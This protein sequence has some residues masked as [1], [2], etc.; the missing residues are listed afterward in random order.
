MGWALPAAIGVKLARPDRQVVGMVGDGDFLMTMQE[1]AT[2][3][4]VG[5]PVVM[6][7]VN[8]QGWLAIKDLQM[9]AFGK[10]RALATDF[11]T[12]DGELYS[13]DIAATASAFGWHAQRRRAQGD[14]AGLEES[15]CLGQAGA[16]RGDGAQGLSAV[17][18]PGRGMV[19]RARA[20]ILEGAARALR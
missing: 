4:Q 5:V 1:M 17:G 8:N 9:D 16:G 20:Y 14:R 6:V 18:Q 2:A 15:N 12:P 19:G 7:V 11:T 13:P 3:M 10:R